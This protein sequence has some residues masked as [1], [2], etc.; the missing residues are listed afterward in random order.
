MISNQI[1]LSQAIIQ[2]TEILQK[3]HYERISADYDAHY[4]DG[5]SQKYMEKFV[6]EPMFKGLDINNKSVLEAMCGGGQTTKYLLNKNARVTGLDI[7]PQQTAHFKKRHREA[8]V[9]C[10]SIL[11][12]GIENETFDIVSVVG[13][14]HHMPPYTR[15]SIAEIH[16]MLK[17]GGYFCF[18]EP[19]SESV[20]E[21]F[22]RAW[23]KRDSL[24]AENEAAVNMSELRA[25]F[26]KLFDFK[27]EHYLGNFGYLLILNSM[28]FRIPL[29]LK[30]L[31]SPS[32]MATEAVLNKVFGKPLSCFVVAQWQK[33]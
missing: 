26:K 7:S 27:H 29:K 30:P 25:D 13:G 5:F 17:P 32:L 11:N 23:Y 6:F 20:A 33:K 21:S 1:Q 28:V 16:R 10:G 24:F 2:K 19:H 22:R 18:M 9:I 12:S 15:E 3:L 14:I 31:Y 4:N 8:D